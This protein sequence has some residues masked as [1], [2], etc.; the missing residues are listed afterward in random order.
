VVH[1]SQRVTA[2]LKEHIYRADR[3][4]ARWILERPG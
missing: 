2:W 4:M 3:E 1:L